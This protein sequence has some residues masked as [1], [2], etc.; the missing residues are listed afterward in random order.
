MQDS[1]QDALA[2]L[3]DLHGAHVEHSPGSCPTST[4]GT[5]CVA[6]SL[7]LD[8]KQQLVLQRRQGLGRGVLLADPK[9]AAQGAAE[10][11]QLLELALAE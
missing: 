6:P 10:V 8:L 5:Q 7:A 4:Q 1:H 9:E 3:I 11:R 2:M